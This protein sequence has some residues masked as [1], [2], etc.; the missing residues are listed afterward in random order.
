ML[1]L[2][3]VS[4]FAQAD[5]PELLNSNSAVQDFTNTLNRSEKASLDAKLKQF[6]N[7]TSTALVIAIVPDLNGYDIVEYADMLGDK[8]KIGQ[9]GKDN[10]ILIVV[11]PKTR[12][13]QGRVRISVGY[14]LEGAV[15]DAIT[16]RIIENEM[17]PHFQRNDYYTA[18]VKSTNVLI[19]LTK[20][21]YTADEYANKS[22]SNRFGFLVPLFAILFFFFFSRISGRRGRTYGSSNLPLWTLLFMGSSMGRGSHHGS[23]NNF[24]GGSG[25]FG[26]GGFGGFGG[27]SFGGGGASGNW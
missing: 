2:G 20:G 4:A 17:I 13:S 22:G 1:V 6:T 15:P 3:S 14:G 8:W 16:K 19:D 9:A 21:E 24:S 12:S 10:G 7:Q 26:G 23:W 27:G 5:L 11:K 25:N 18:L